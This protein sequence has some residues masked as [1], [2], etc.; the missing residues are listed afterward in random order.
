M[1]TELVAI[2]LGSALV[3]RAAAMMLTANL[4]KQESQLGMEELIR[5]YIPGLKHQRSLR[6]QFEQITD[7]VAARIEPMLAHE[8]R[9][10]D[11]NEQ[12][13]VVQ[14]VIDSFEQADLG[15]SAI[16]RADA[17]P[18]ILARDIRKTVTAP[19]GLSE[20]AS[21]L[22]ERLIAESCDY[23]VRIVRHL[24]VFTERA[25]VELLARI[26]AIGSEV[27]R[28]VERV[29]AR[30]LYSPDGS[31]RDEAFRQK[32]LGLVSTTLDDVEVFSFSTEK[33]LRTK[34]S[35]AYISLRASGHR[36]LKRK[37]GSDADVDDVSSAATSSDRSRLG[38]SGSSVR[39]E[40][41][42]SSESRVLL[43][44]EA[45]S[46]KT[47]L[48]RWLAI[49]AAR[50]S[51]SQSLSEWN[52]LVP[53]LVVL[54]SYSSRA[55]PRLEEML[56]NA[57]GAITGIM[58]SGWVDRQF[59]ASRVLLLVDGVDELLPKERSDVRK[60]LQQILAIYPTIRVVVTSRP[61]AASQDWLIDEEFLPI[62]LERMTR[63]DLSVFIRQWHQAVAVH[64]KSLPCSLEELPDYE[65]SLVRSLIDRE[66][67]YSLASNPLLAAMLCSL[68]LSRYRQLPRNRM[69]LYQIAV[70]LL[71]QRRDSDRQVPSATGMALSYAQKRSVL[72]D[73]AWRL[74]D[75]NRSELGLEKAKQYVF[76]KV[77]SMRQIDVEP[78]AVMDYLL[79]RSGILRSPSEG[80]INFVHRTFQE[81]LAA[82][83]AASQDRIGNL[84]GRAHL[85]LWRET[86]VMAAGHANASQRLELIS[87]ILERVE[88]E[89]RYRRRLRMLVVSCLETIEALD[90]ELD[91]CID[92]ALDELVPPRRSD[93]AWSL[94][95]V[96][97]AV[98]RK[99]PLTLDGISVGSAA[100]TVRTA[101]LIGGKRDRE[102]LV[103]YA[104]DRRPEV[105]RALV[106]AWDFASDI[107]DFAHQVLAKIETSLGLRLRLQSPAQ[108]EPAM[109][110]PSVSSISVYYP[111]S[112][113]EMDF[114][115]LPSVS[116]LNF[117][118]LVGDND[119]SSLGFIPDPD[120]VRQ[121]SFVAISAQDVLLKGINTLGCFKNLQS[122]S[123]EGKWVSTAETSE[124]WSLPASLK[125]LAIDGAEAYTGEFLDRC[126]H[127]SVIQLSGHSG[128]SALKT[129]QMYSIEALSLG[130]C[131]LATDFR[132][133]I[134]AA[135][136]IH[137][138]TLFAAR[139]PADLSVLL[140]LQNLAT[141]SL[142][143]CVGGPDH[144]IDL[145]PLAKCSK[146][147]EMELNRTK[148][149]GVPTDSDSLLT[150]TTI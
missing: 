29:P 96:G 57:A 15:D 31:D 80:K 93:D 129:R 55:L 8:Y 17:D 16:L 127:I 33:N 19:A 102:L 86:I 58:P 90:D 67:L 54:R 132:A 2:R 98:S 20:P 107:A 114:T 83:E 25:V 101:A 51:F 147:L 1:S 112:V 74:S 77:A 10:L 97:E 6:R 14:A 103:S 5:R 138:I 70:E 124:S 131:D 115:R 56:D 32:Y 136:N 11:D 92:A 89:P 106:E 81:Y 109:E 34:L 42:L 119:L 139:L 4:R 28:M 150:V 113:G 45:G 116:A 50:G 22:Y 46:G 44:G 62:S 118:G 143:G 122:L 137:H 18:V 144:E 100:A 126:P 117:Y 149:I 128:V 37:H 148:V 88:N 78:Q 47:T 26:S 125:S 63:D 35:L 64:E 30:T 123:V 99:L 36:R 53:I 121:L 75:N 68:N 146:P 43:R 72:R 110:L 73:L 39:I 111:I 59:N 105:H 108:W 134:G 91:L 84:I 41:I 52:G 76:A 94:A 9:G 135:P 24:P 38:V 12:A 142:Y 65:R 120:A 85:D 133:V 61:A 71:V 95:Q 48:L 145:S 27:A 3:G 79:V 66:H 87:G 104:R 140:E 13:A 130:Q 82:E 49:T 60:W 23:Y 40:T 21:A 7:A 69:E 141:I